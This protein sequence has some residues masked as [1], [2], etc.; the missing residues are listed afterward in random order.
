MNRTKCISV[1]LV[2][3]LLLQLIPDTWASDRENYYLYVK[4]SISIIEEYLEGPIISF[5]FNE[6]FWLLL[7]AG[8]SC[9]L[10]PINAVNTLI[11]VSSFLLSYILLR[12]SNVSFKWVLLILI[13]TPI[14]TMQFSHIRQAIALTIFLAGYFYKNKYSAILLLLSALTH[15]SFFFILPLIYLV[16]FLDRSLPNSLFFLKLNFILMYALTLTF[17]MVE[18][19]QIFGARQS[20]ID[21]SVINNTGNAFIFWIIIIGLFFSQGLQFVNKSMLPV[22]A[23]LIFLVSYYYNPFVVRIFDNLTVFILLKGAEL[24][25]W[26]VYAFVIL[27]LTYISISY[28][29]LVSNEI[30]F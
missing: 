15:S 9:I 12:K 21:I 18:L 4:N 17:F 2:Y 30:S 24:R 14:F 3:G 19:A 28:Y 26:R 25:N 29:I 13:F 7:N 20:G 8:L 10:E 11:F 22:S 5:F 16:K 27:I 1:S 6:P 23:I